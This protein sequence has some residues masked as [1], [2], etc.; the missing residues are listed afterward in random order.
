MICSLSLVEGAFRCD[1]GFDFA[2]PTALT[3][4]YQFNVDTV[5]VV[6]EPD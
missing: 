6:P 5:L 3:E 2:Q 4:W 1:T